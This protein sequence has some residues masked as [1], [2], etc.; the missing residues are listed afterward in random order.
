MIKLIHGLDLCTI[1]TPRI[2]D[3]QN[4]ILTLN[5]EVQIIPSDRIYGIPVIWWRYTETTLVRTKHWRIL[6]TNDETSLNL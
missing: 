4:L 1:G 3:N 5:S 6:K 2:G